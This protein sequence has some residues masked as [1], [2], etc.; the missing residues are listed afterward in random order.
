MPVRSLSSSVRKWPDP[1]SVLEGVSRWAASVAESQPGVL[2]VGVFGSYGRGDAGVGSDLD[3][4]ILVNADDR[5]LHQRLIG[6]PEELPLPA[7]VLVFT[8]KEWLDMHERGGR[9]PETLRR[10]T[11]WL[12]GT[13]PDAGSSTDH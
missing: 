3:I 12:H 11:R 2:A 6:A 7:D 8:R 1:G 4:I 13:D 10:E 5:P 9:F